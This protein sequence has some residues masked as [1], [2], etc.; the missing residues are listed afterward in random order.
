VI[1]R[2]LTEQ[3]LFCTKCVQANPLSINPR[4]KH[5]V[6]VEWAALRAY[7]VCQ[8]CHLF[9]VPDEDERK[10]LLDVINGAV[11]IVGARRKTPAV[12]TGSMFCTPC[13][14][15][16]TTTPLSVHLKSPTHCSSLLSAVVPLSGVLPSSENPSVLAW[17]RAM[18]IARQ[19]AATT[20][21]LADPLAVVR[22]SEA[23]LDSVAGRFVQ[24]LLVPYEDAN[25]QQ[26]PFVGALKLQQRQV[27]AA[28]RVD[29]HAHS[30]TR[31]RAC[32]C[33]GARVQRAARLLAGRRLVQHQQ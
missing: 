31:A 15:K 19:R 5:P 28:V 7:C 16:T 23:L 2:V 3:A 32:A 22:P 17:E 29:T 14:M 4:A 27:R 24:S 30:H 8:H 18:A 11:S 13:G 1:N 9:L 20:R 25:W 6:R 10:D 33:I 26:L 12:N 21:L